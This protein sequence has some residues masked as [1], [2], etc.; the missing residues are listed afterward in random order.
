MK[1]L[2]IKF[3]SGFFA[4][5]I[6]LVIP[7]TTFAIN[8][9]VNDVIGYVTTRDNA[10]V[11]G[12]WVKWEGEKNQA[13]EG[14]P[15]EN[16]NA[17]KYAMTDGSGKFVFPWWYNP[18][19]EGSDG[20]TLSLGNDNYRAKEFLTWIKPNQPE[21]A[22]DTEAY[23][24]IY[25]P[26]MAWAGNNPKK[27]IIQ[28]DHHR[29]L[30]VLTNASKYRPPG[31]GWVRKAS[32]AQ[33]GGGFQCDNQ[34]TISVVPPKNWQGTWENN[35]IRPGLANGTGPIIIDTKIIYNAPKPEGFHDGNGFN[36]NDKTIT[37]SKVSA[38]RCLVRGW[39]RVLESDI[40][41]YA[42]IYYKD[43]D[44]SGNE[45]GEFKDV[46]TIKSD[47]FRQD[48]GG[49]YSF[50]Y[51]LPNEFKDG[52]PRRYHVFAVN[53]FDNPRLTN[54]PRDMVCEAIPEEQR[55]SPTPQPVLR[56]TVDIW[57]ESGRQI[58]GRGT[59]GGT[60]TINPNQATTIAW[61]AKNSSLCVGSGNWAGVKKA[62]VTR[63]SK[64]LTKIES[65]ATYNHTLTCF[66]N[67]TGEQ[68]SDTVIIRVSSTDKPFIQTT[69]GDVHS[70]EDISVPSTP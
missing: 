20:S 47:K 17:T 41:M 44:S 39:T 23:D 7:N 16:I 60:L 18:T 22:P 67:E 52:K 4:L 50:E 66:N 30:K 46:A 70:N 40:P 25:L 14:W 42:A 54:S 51:N 37:S 34:P 9:G 11:K 58:T 48:L 56:P 32:S 59:P 57:A 21:V 15:D 33:G 69:E 19:Y 55:P 1:K 27:F 24:T 65:G 26:N 29:Y 53:S 35:G 63:L 13:Q 5:L 68:E 61:T 64:Q 62:G 2:F 28:D 43:V 6:I 12:V 45:I 36:S 31:E 38:D 3:I 8:G 49:N 10:P